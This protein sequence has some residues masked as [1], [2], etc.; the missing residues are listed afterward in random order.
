MNVISLS[1]DSPEELA[2]KLARRAGKKRL[3]KNWSRRTLADRAGISLSSYR[4]FETTGK[5]SFSLVL[6]VAFVLDSL[7]EF[8]ELFAITE[9]RSIAE[10]E[11]LSRRAPRKRGRK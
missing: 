2:M 5:G 11:K 4:R 6:K 1:I 7:Q 3:Q 10:L 8:Q 9:A